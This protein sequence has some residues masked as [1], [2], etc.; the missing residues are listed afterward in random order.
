MTPWDM[1][2]KR[3]YLYNYFIISMAKTAK[4]RF[5]GQ[6]RLREKIWLGCFI[7]RKHSSGTESV[8]SFSEP[9][10]T[11]IPLLPH[12]TIICLLACCLQNRHP[13]AKG[14]CPHTHNK[15]SGSQYRFLSRRCG[16]PPVCAPLR[17]NLLTLPGHV[18]A[19]VK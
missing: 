8:M 12:N 11:S 14:K 2:K 10:S 18:T 15:P 19:P 5:I 6:A 3:D 7:S 16:G 1:I 9:D 4:I 17:K 13:D